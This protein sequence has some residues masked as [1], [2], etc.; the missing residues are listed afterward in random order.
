MKGML[1]ILQRIA[2]QSKTQASNLLKKK[3]SFNFLLKLLIF[4]SLVVNKTMKTRRDKEVA[5]NRI[6][7]FMKLEPMNL[8]LDKT[9]M[10]KIMGMIIPRLRE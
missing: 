2:Y 4:S 1:K 8:P 5:A 7:V 3:P 6:T 9:V 10:K